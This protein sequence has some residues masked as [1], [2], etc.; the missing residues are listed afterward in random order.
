MASPDVYDWPR[1]WYQYIVTQKFNL[2]SLNQAAGVGWGG[3]GQAISSLATQLWLS[4]VTMAPM[5]D[6]ILQ[7]MDAFF[8]R[9]RG[10][11][12]VMRIGNALRPAPWHDRSLV[13]GTSLWDDGSTFTDGSGFTSGL[14]PPEV[15]V[16]T[17]AAQGASYI[18]LGGF[19]VS[20]SRALHR[21]DLLQI[22]PNGIPGTVPHLYKTMWT[23]DSNS[24]G[25]IGVAI[26]PRLRV[27]IAAG[28]VV[29]LRYATTLFRLADDT[30]GEIEITGGGMGNF[31]FS[32]VEALDLVP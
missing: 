12:G 5:Q 26:E 17:A 4:D 22:K 13:A 3:A 25:Q 24:S 32:L 20:L 8:A 10:R 14:L 7:D 6:P 27:G 2:R 11:S 1:D 15:Y 31:G 19:P 28:D 23:A 16:Q 9:L 29:G 30:Q 18:V 21:G